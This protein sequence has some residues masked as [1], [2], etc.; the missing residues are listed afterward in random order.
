MDKIKW[1]VLTYTLPAEP[2]RPRVAVWRAL[3]KIG[4]VNIQQSMWVLPDYAEHLS[5]LRKICQDIE[6]AGGEALLM[7]SVFYE[8]EHAQRVM[9]L[10]NRIRDEEYTE[11]IEESGKYL[12]EIQKEIDREKFIFAELE[13]EEAEFEKLSAW[14]V[15]ITARDLF[16]ASQSDAAM[17]KRRQIETAISGYSQMVYEHET[18]F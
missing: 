10:F 2:S 8:D 7:E 1:I 5:A 4:A 11:F 14:F 15:K 9:N 17:E 12:R 16:H 13:E 18:S 6:A 3:K